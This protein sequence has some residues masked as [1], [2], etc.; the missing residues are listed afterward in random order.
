MRRYVDWSHW[1]KTV[2]HD[3]SE[4]KALERELRRVQA[5][6]EEAARATT[7]HL[8]RINHEMRTPLA[9]L[10]SYADMMAARAVS[11]TERKEFAQGVR[12][13]AEQLLALL[14]ELVECSQDHAEQF[15]AGVV[16]RTLD[17]LARNVDAT[18]VNAAVAGVGLVA[19]GGGSQTVLVVDDA[20]EM[21][22]II[23]TRLQLARVSL[24]HAH[25]AS[26]GLALAREHLPDLVLLDLHMPGTGGLVLC[27][28]LKEDPALNG[29][30]VIVLTGAT[31]LS[32]KV[33]AFEMGA[34]DYVT[35]PFD[36]VELRARVRSALRIK[37]YQ[38]LL[39]SQ[40]QIDALTGLW[41]RGYLDAQLA[42]NIAV[43][44]RQGSPVTLLLADLDDFKSLNDNY[45]HPF[46]D[47][48]IQRVA[49]EFSEV[50]RESDVV[51]RYGGEEFAVILK[52]T[53]SAAAAGIA[54]RLRLAVEKICLNGGHEHVRVTTSIGIAGSDQFEDC[55]T[56][57]AEMLLSAADR[58]LYRAKSRGRNRVE[59][60]ATR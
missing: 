29:V 16:P 9:A 25:D 32:T 38:D 5:N 57:T 1:V 60:S 53:S 28:Q 23:R 36:A 26:M 14:T 4:K 6:A 7:R 48:V 13:S 31:D 24:L 19:G 15:D 42:I 35:K 51:C 10:L 47:S 37:R 52:D 21:H 45:G 20:P 3:V 11:D 58:A 2:P 33:H 40:A 41:N 34:S 18:S 43:T 44:Q 22:E 17:K 12:R 46:G 50:S 56:L 39:A 54:E 30:P 59:M 27:R 49:E 55:S 8:A